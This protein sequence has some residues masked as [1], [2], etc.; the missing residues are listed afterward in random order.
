MDF[1]AILWTARKWKISGGF[2]TSSIV[3]SRKRLILTSRQSDFVKVR[4]GYFAGVEY[5]HWNNPVSMCLMINCQKIIF[6]I[7]KNLVCQS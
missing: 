6:L 2:S 5:A 4:N 3:V 7:V 1:K